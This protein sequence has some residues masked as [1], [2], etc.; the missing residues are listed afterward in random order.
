MRRDAGGVLPAICRIW[1]PTVTALAASH[2]AAQARGEALVEITRADALE[3][4][5]VMAPFQHG[6]V[7]FGKDGAFVLVQR[8]RFPKPVRADVFDADLEVWRAVDGGARWRRVAV[9]PTRG[10]ADGAIARDGD[11]LA[12]CWTASNGKAWGDAWFQRFD[13]AR[14][15]WLGE[16]ERLTDAT[17]AEDQ[18]FCTDLAR[19]GDGSLVAVI[20]CHRSP[21]APAWNC[22]WSTGV[23]ILPQGRG[24]WTPIE[25]ANDA[26][27]GVCGNALARGDVVDLTFRTCPSDAVHGLRRVAATKGR[28]AEPTPPITPPDPGEDD[29]VAN[30]G[31]LC[32]DDVGGRTLL[33]L[34]GNRSAGKGR[35]SVAFDRGD[36]A[37]AVRDLADDPA[38]VAGNETNAS[39]TLA[40]GP[41]NLVHAVFTK[42]SDGGAELWHA[43]LADGEVVQAPRVVAKGAAKSFAGLNGMREPVASSSLRAVV[44]SR[45]EDE[46]GGVVRAFGSWPIRNVAAR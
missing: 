3:V 40:R 38:L 44:V 29:A 8:A 25:Q 32:G 34:R 42:A 7:P 33:F 20:G 16:P 23:R 35:L 41:G 43:T 4:V 15:A 14:E 18:Y 13:P 10:D 36:G 17:D 28:L 24:A 22:G 27:Y 39:F 12:V 5:A 45:A 31:I 1:L 6:C 21:P 37:F 26:S 9:T 19:A 11:L 30:V 2:A 46:P